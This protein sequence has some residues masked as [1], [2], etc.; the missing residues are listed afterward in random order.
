[1][2]HISRKRLGI[3]GGLIL[4]I[5]IAI[6]LAAWV[7]LLNTN[8]L[9]TLH[10]DELQPALEKY[11]YQRYVQ[12]KQ[13]FPRFSGSFSGKVGFFRVISY[14]PEC[15][16]IE[17]QYTYIGISSG[18]NYYLLKNNSNGWEITDWAPVVDPSTD[19][20]TN[21]RLAIP[22]TCDDG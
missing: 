11:Y 14:Q 6:V 20:F 19:D 22:F 16:I 15:S 17:A 4:V 13:E 18:T 9:T 5:T 8:R 7:Y 3:L 2:R 10:Q 12:Y 1:M 21:K